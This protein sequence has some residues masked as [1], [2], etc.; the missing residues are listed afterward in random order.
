MARDLKS[1]FPF[2]P[3]D[4]EFLP[5]ATDDIVAELKTLLASARDRLKADGITDAD[6]PG[7]LTHLITFAMLEAGITN[8]DDDNSE[9]A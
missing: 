3:P 2:P 5:D 7:F 1:L 6:M 4:A 8:L 9:A